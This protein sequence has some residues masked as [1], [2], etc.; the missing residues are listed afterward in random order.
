MIRLSCG[1]SANQLGAG[2]PGVSRWAHG[3]EAVER[4]EARGTP[5]HIRLAK[6]IALIDLFRNNTGIVAEL[7]IVRASLADID[8]TWSTAHSMT[9]RSGRSS[10]SASTSTHGHLRGQRFR[11]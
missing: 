11:H 8:G 4:C 7:D 2:D 6:T 5:L 1:L 3:A 10:F 9:S